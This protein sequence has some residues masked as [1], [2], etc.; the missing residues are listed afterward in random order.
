MNRLS[1]PRWE[2]LVYHLEQIS[3]YHLPLEMGESSYGVEYTGALQVTNALAFT[4]TLL[5]A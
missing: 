5:L 1:F 2:L 4:G 3:Q